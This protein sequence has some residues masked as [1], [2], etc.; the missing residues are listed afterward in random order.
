M[1]ALERL[2]L[3]LAG[4]PPKYVNQRYPGKRG[5]GALSV[6]EASTLELLERRRSVAREGEGFGGMRKEGL[7]RRQQRGL[8][9]QA[10]WRRVLPLILS[11]HRW[12]KNA[13]TLGGVEER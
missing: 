4:S 8:A 13:E 6:E 2:G 7:V 1:S 3:L 10:R 9:C 12:A 5:K 11:F